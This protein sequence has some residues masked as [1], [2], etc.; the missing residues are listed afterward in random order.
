MSRSL[1][2]NALYLIAEI[3]GNHEGSFE[4]AKEQCRL[5]IDSGADC[6]KF[7]LYSA[8][9]LVNS[10]ESP[11]RHAHFKRF[12]LS[13]EQH[14]T[15]AEMCQKA[16]RD[17]LAS[18]WESGMIGWVDGYLNS[19]KIGS[20]DL[21]ALSM[22]REFAKRGKPIIL[23]TGLS[24]LREVKWAVE[25]IRKANVIYNEEGM[26]ILMQCTSMYPIP[27]SDA[28][29]A[30]IESLAEIPGVT[31]GYSDHTV[32]MEAL[33]TS[34]ALG[35][36]VLEFHFTDQREGR[37]FRDHKVSLMVDEVKELR[38]RCEQVITLLGHQNKEPLEIETSNGHVVSFRRA[39]YPCRD[40]PAGKIIEESDLIS[41]R[42]CNGIG[43]QHLDA[44]IGLTLNQPVKRLQPLDMDMFL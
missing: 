20:G 13:R 4:V 17:Y 1:K 35:A 23:S 37:E 32:G 27:D 40:L 28:N 24:T 34:V 29:L 5:A 8:D 36:R 19:Y 14:I 22:L 38:Q 21:T 2:I 12:E 3:G 7:Q 42:P 31:V 43:A 39:L 6:V 33:V 26:I 10:V 41:L 44:I 9:G 30:V 11:E 18:I 15:L 25:E 16:G